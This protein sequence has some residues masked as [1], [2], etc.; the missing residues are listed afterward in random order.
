MLP[1]LIFFLIFGLSNI[2]GLMAQKNI[3]PEYFEGSIQYSFKLTG[4]MASLMSSFMP[5]SMIFRF[6]ENNIA[7]NTIGGMMANMGNVV[8]SGKDNEAFMIDNSARKAYKLGRKSDDLKPKPPLVVKEQEVID[9]A[10]YPCVKYKVVTRDKEG[11]AQ[12]SYLWATE[13]IQIKK[14]ESP[15]ADANQLQGFMIKG[16]N[17]VP[18]KMMNTQA[19][20]GTIVLTALK[21]TKE[22][23]EDNL[24]VV[25]QGYTLEDFDPMKMMSR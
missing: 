12:I 15:T 6:K 5:E 18:L 10:G 1:N 20:V 2:S 7:M 16:V 9:I 19:S 13:K 3:E 21:V 25:P 24:F 11:N 14:S 4:D 17:G 23:L 8:Y 22:K